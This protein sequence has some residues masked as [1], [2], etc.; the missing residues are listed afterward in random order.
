MLRHFRLYKQRRL[1]G[2]NASGQPVNHHVP[3]VLLDLRRAIVMGGQR[4]PV[5]DK[6]ETLMLVL[7]AHP[8]FEHAVIVTK[9][10]RSGR[11]HA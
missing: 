10:Q 11:T 6:K 5:G 1:R 2:I 9:V 8:V 3:G 4:V 7:Q